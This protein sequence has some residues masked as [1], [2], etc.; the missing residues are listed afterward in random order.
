MELIENKGSLV[1]LRLTNKPV[2]L[3]LSNAKTGSYFYVTLVSIDDKRVEIAQGTKIKT[4]SVQDIS[5]IWSGE[6]ILLWK[7]PAFYKRKLRIGNTGD[8]V[9]WLD[10]YQAQVQRRPATGRKVY[11]SRLSD[12]VKEFQQSVGLTPDGIVGPMTILYLQGMLGN[13]HPSLSVREVNP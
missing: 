9:E 13:D 8:M 3:K 12:Y 7:P 2:V 11:E 10:K 4:F 1:D 5:V 6:N